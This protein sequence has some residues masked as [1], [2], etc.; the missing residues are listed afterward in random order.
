MTAP[1]GAEVGIHVDLVA[2]VEVGDVIETDTGRRYG[3]VAVRVQA[4]GKHRGRQHLRVVV[5][6]KPTLEEMGRDLALRATY[7]GTGPRPPPEPRV[8][9]I[10]WYKRQ[11]RKTKYKASSTASVATEVT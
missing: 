3:V 4:K 2:R 11:S 6:H 10:R 1:V 5:L 9:T 7:N 8:H